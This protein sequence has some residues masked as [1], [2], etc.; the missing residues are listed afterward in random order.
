MAR[1]A[2]FG[3]DLPTTGAGAVNA[4]VSVEGATEDRA[5][6]RAAGE[7]VAATGGHLT[8]LNVMP[9]GAFADRQFARERV[10]D[11]PRFTLAQAEEERRRTAEHVAREALAGVPVEYECVGV[12]GREPAC[13]L[14]EARARGCSHVFV[15]ARRR[16]SLGAVGAEDVVRAVVESF[17]G[18]VTVLRE[19]ADADPRP[20]ETVHVPGRGRPTTAGTPHSSR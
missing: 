13:I 16:S 14:A 18:T 4:L 15:V 1:D 19:A 11:L 20:V 7:F 5:A 2:V 8:V 9:G 3:G 12:V 10:P 6:V 17:D